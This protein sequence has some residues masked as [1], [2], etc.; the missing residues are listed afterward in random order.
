MRDGF[1]WLCW[2]P[3]RTVLP[4]WLFLLVIVVMRTLFK[5]QELYGKIGELAHRSHT[6]RCLSFTFDVCDIVLCM[7]VVCCVVSVRDYLLF[8]YL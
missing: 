8:L 4:G 1:F 2:L 7:C 3:G 5:V 6:S